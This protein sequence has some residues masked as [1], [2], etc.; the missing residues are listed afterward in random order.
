MTSEVRK[1]RGG[2]REQPSPREHDAQLLV[3]GGDEVGVVLSLTK[4]ESVGW[5]MDGEAH[6]WF[7]HIEG[8]RGANGLL[9]RL[10]PALKEPGVRRLAAI[11][12]ADDDGMEK[13]LEQVRTQLDNLGMPWKGIPRI[14][15]KPD[16]N[17]LVLP[18]AVEGFRFGLWIMPDNRAEGALEDF[19]RSLVRPGD[20]LWTHAVEATRQ[21]EEKGAEF[22][23]R[24]RSKAEMRAWLAWQK[25]PVSIYQHALTDGVFGANHR[26]R[27]DVVARFLHWF[28]RMF[29]PGSRLDDPTKGATC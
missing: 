3:E 21:A 15:E 19:L 23:N 11:L 8:T 6:P 12:D 18:G 1:G 14:P 5:R 7:P 22:G 25:T 27:S 28:Q 17:G 10:A 16:P 29:D 24:R 2:E 13:R 20:R 4:R 9:R 26:D